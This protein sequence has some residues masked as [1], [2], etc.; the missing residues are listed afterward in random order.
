M[1]D[2]AKSVPVSIGRAP[3]LATRL[4]ESAPC[5]PWTVDYA[6]AREVWREFRAAEGFDAEQPPPFTAAG[7]SNAKLSKSGLPTRSLTL[8]PWKASAAWNACEAA[9]AQCRAACV[10]MTAGRGRI[11]T[12][13]RGRV[14]RTRFLGEHPAEALAL[15]AEELRRA[16]EQY[17]DVLVRLNV[18]SDLPWERIAPALFDIPGV[19]GYDYTKLDPARRVPS[20]R[21]R[22]V[23]SVSEAA[24][25][26]PTALR[27][28]SEGG[29]AA[30]VFDTPLGSALPA[31][32]RG[33]PVVDGDVSDD[34]TADPRGAV[35]GL[36]AKGAA[37]KLP[38]GGFVQSAAPFEVCA[39]AAL[40]CSPE[41]FPVRIR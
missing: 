15:I 27:Y 36:R 13:L 24:H 31:A 10:L 18:A 39:S 4:L 26:I 35:V 33:F 40:S 29:T 23:Y 25:S 32:W 30:V 41:S 34:R 21:Y 5:D 1:Q 9:T 17:G 14:S 19:R 28:M 37:R 3:L 2:N 8:A 6:T 22:I 38:A 16:G 11:P 20:D 12:V 7:E